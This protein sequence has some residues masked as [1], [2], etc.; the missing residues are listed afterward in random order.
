M[1]FGVQ[2]TIRPRARLRQSFLVTHEPDSAVASC[3]GS[4][5]CDRPRKSR[6]FRALSHAKTCQNLTFFRLARRFSC[7]FCAPFSV[8]LEISKSARHNELAPRKEVVRKN[9]K[10]FF[11]LMSGTISYKRVALSAWCTPVQ[12][13][14]RIEAK[15]ARV[16]LAPCLV[17]PVNGG[18]RQF[19]NEI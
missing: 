8:F 13:A 10:L 11:Y 1:H 15:R 4:A 7:S 5:R 6:I 12:N 9:G 14:P 18:R 16:Q 2:R 17:M 19:L 3:D